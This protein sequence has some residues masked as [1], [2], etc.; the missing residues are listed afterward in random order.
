M[1]N[2]RYPSA[3]AVRPWIIVAAVCI[4][5]ATFTQRASAAEAEVA[6]E[7]GKEHLVELSLE[8][9][10]Y[11]VTIDTSESPELSGWAE[12]QLA[13][14]V[15]EWYPMIAHMLPSKGFEPPKVVDI[16]ISDSI[17][18]VAYTAGDKVR[19]NGNWF[20]RQLD[21]EA[22]GAVVHELVHVVQQYGRRRGSRPP[23]WL[24]EGIPDY[25]RW[26][27]YEPQSGGALI[28]KDFADRARHDASYRTSANF[29]NWVSNRYGASLTPK[30]N[31]RL[32]EGRYEASF[33]EEYTGQSL[34]DLAD[35]WKESLRTG[36]E[37]A[38]Q[39]VANQLAVEE[40][41]QG[42]RLLFDGQSLDG[43]HSFHRDQVRPGWQVKDG[44]LTCANPRDAGDLCTDDQYEW[45]ELELDYNISQGGNSGLLFHVSNEGPATWASGPEFQLED[46]M[47]AH[48]P[49][50]CGW[51]YAL[52]QPPADDDT[53][54]PIDATLP[55]GRWN[56]VRLV[57]APDGC[58][59]EINGRKYLEYKLGS[60]EFNQRVSAS[61][62]SRMPLFAKQATGMIAL[63]GDHGV[64]SFR[65]IKIRKIE[66]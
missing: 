59:H 55:A 21:G 38:P 22:I 17:G 56:H 40:Q 3:H 24:V 28:G 23:G 37:E 14:V 29:I 2:S 46:N 12:K 60:E 5:G 42:W 30:L 16:A 64:V 31:A 33:W 1:Q 8:D 65:N 39:E 52:Y 7:A 47:E 45:F 32:R 34:S 57:V 63:Q 41:Q 4:V 35:A 6:Q 44:V 25:V 15:A 13:P 19:C 11:R 9:G 51:L 53:G 20:K 27:L 49:T 36:E 50:R 62:F 10:R 26:F 61:K 58:I 48:D 66:P 54:Q 18:G 43:W